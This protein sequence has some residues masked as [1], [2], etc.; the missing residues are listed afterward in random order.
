MG[1]FGTARRRLPLFGLTLVATL[2]VAVGVAGATGGDARL[3]NDCH[4]TPAD[5]AAGATC[6][7]GYVSAYTLATGVPYTDATLD[8]C[9]V[10]HG[11]QN[12]P[13]VAVDPR[14]TSVVLGSSNDYCGVYNA[15]DAGGNPVAT[16]PIWLGYYRSQD[17]GTSWVS[18]LVPGYPG[19]TSPYA[20]LAQIRTASAGDPVI[21][22]DTHGRAFFGSE[23]SGDPSGTAKGFGDLWVAR[24]VNPD[25]PDA[26]TTARDGLRYL[27]TTTVAKGSSSPAEGKF[28]DKTAIEVDR[29]GGPCDGNVYFAWSRFTASNSNIYFVRSTDHGATFS[30]PVLVTSSTKNVQD[31]EVSVTANGHVYVTWDQGDTNSGQPEGVGV[32]KSVSCGATFSPGKLLVSYVGYEA[33]DV[34]APA[35]MSQPQAQRDDALSAER[36]AAGSTARDCGDFA[37]HCQSGY[38][39]FRQSTSTRATADQKDTAHEWLYLTYAAIRGPVVPTGTTYGNVA[40]GE[41]GRTRV[42]FLRYDGATGQVNVPPRLVDDQAA[43]QQVFPDLAIEGGALH[44]VWWDSRSDPCDDITRPIGN[45]A[46]RSTVPSIEAYASRSTDRGLTFA[47]SSVQSATPSNPNYE[48]FDNRAVPFAGDYLWVTALGDFAYSTWTDW[49]N[50]VA[51]NDPREVTPDPDAGNADV[52]QCRVLITTTDKKGNTSS[53]WSGDRCPHAGGLDQDIYGTKTP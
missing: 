39:F 44:F 38:T 9:T 50:T 19:D 45:C 33:Q 35:A 8:E 30:N 26:P 46:N 27:G 18:S 28:N 6:G 53:S 48:Q 15:A 43:G 24:F 22:W 2:A 7:A 14:N 47:P 31:P 11:R 42:Y 16:G 32:A 17:S 41:A 3:T 23:S 51:G 10:A 40:V 29:T 37:D 52:V 25:G 12:E 5:K 49:R 21:A 20:A 36:E 13:S 34:S 4:P 1:H